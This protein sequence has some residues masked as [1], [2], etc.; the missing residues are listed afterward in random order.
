MILHNM[1]FSLFI[2]SN[3]ISMMSLVVS[4]ILTV[5]AKIRSG[6]MVTSNVVLPV[7]SEQHTIIRHCFWCGTIFAVLD[8]LLCF[9]YIL[10]VDEDTASVLS[11]GLL[12]FGIVWSILI[13]FG[14]II[15]IV[16][17]C[18]K[19]KAYICSV[20][21]GIRSTIFYAFICFILSFLIA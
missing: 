16:I 2:V 9:S 4:Y 20:A 10:P 19:S 17:K 21:N 15:E 1:L 18:I 7:F 5:I 12:I 11:E 6:V 14:V 8:W 13:F 3:I